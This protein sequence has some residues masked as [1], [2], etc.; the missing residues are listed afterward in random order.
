MHREIAVVLAS[1]G[2]D[3]A[4]TVA[5]AGQRFRLALL[6]LNYGQRTMARELRAFNDL[7]DFYGAEA[8]LVVD[9]QHLSQIGGSSLTDAGIQVAKADLASREIPS[10]YVPFRNANL[11]AIAT[12]WAEVL[13]ARR[14]FVGAVEEDSSGYPDCRRAFYDAFER[15]IAVGTRPETDIRIE[16]PV[17]GLKKHEIV[18]KGLELGVPFEL[19]WSCYQRED[20]ACGVC[21]S[22]G[23]RLRGFQQAGVEDPL[24]Y[25]ERPVYL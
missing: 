15:V 9:V 8:R 19:T 17:I 23:F 2:M 11:L 24:P 13:G 25:A 14:I 21:D 3:S 6:H 12:S 4:V 7:A 1:G 18:K 5:I 20:V 22:C 16:T 10:S